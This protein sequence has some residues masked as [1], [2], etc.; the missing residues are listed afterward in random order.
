MTSAKT[1]PVDITG[2]PKG[3]HIGDKKIT[4]KDAYK[5]VCDYVETGS[6]TMVAEMN[7]QSRTSVTRHIKAFIANNPEEFQKILDAFLARNKQEMI[8]SNTYTTVKAL[9]KVNEMLDDPS[10]CK[11]VKDVAMTYGILYDKGALMKGEA[12]QNSAIVIKM[13]GDIEELSK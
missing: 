2:L 4:A 7:K 10:A 3:R 1:K 13:S 5:F 6:Y 12:T 8:L 9:D 11:S